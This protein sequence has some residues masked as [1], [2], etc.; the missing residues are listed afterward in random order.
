M[1]IDQCQGFSS[2]TKRD[3][4]RLFQNAWKTLFTPENIYSGFKATSLHPFDPQLI[5]TKF[6]K[7]TEDRPSS[8]SSRGSAIAAEDWKRIE[9][10]LYNV[11]GNVYDKKAQKLS[12]TM[13]ALSIENML[14]KQQNNGLKQSLVNE[15]KRRKRGKPLL[16]DFPTENDGGAMFFSPTK[17]QHARD[18]QAQK[19][20][21]A[22]AERY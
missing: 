9:K 19:D 10:L 7:D 12:N 14:L 2:I 13:H 18:Q 11:V 15:K 3:F 17:V 16:L 4:F 8:S 22:I 20:A 6:T 5:I 1:F 21:N